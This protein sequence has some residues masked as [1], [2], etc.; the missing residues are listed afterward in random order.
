MR[1]LAAGVSLGF[2]LSL[3][4]VKAAV[5]LLSGSVALLASLVDSL[6]DAVAS[7]ILLFGILSAQRPPDAAYRFGY[8]KAEAL[9]AMAQAA[10]IAGA[11]SLVALEAVEGLLNPVPISHDHVVIAVAGLAMVTTLGLVLFQNWVIRETGSVAIMADLLHYS[12]DLLLNAAVIAS[13]VLA[14][15]AGWIW[16][17][18]VAGLVIALVLACGV[19]RIGRRAVHELMDRDLPEAERQALLRAATGV[20]GIHGAH[21]LRSRRSGGRMFIELHVEL[22]PALPLRQVRERA[23]AVEAAIAAV[24]PEA[25]VTIVTDPLGLREERLDDRIAAAGPASS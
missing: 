8:G 2:A 23:F 22:D 13:V 19:W 6:V 10:L 25:E 17:D 24:H 1:R 16:L 15:I 18:P 20:A 7:G 3:I 21:D 11:A 5:W 12:G 14:D 9:A 4:V